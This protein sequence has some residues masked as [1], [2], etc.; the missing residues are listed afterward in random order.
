MDCIKCDSRVQKFGKVKQRQRYQCLNCGT[1]FTEISLL[2]IKERE[3]KYIKIKDM[4]ILSGMSTTE[5]GKALSTS[6]TVPQRILKKMGI[7]RTISEAKKGKLRGTSLP[8]GVIIERYCNGESSYAIAKD[9]GYAKSSILNILEDNGIPRDNEY[10]YEH[11]N[12]IEMLGMYLDGCSMLVISKTLNIPYTT[13]NTR[14][15]KFSVVR[16]ED[17]HGLGINYDDYVKILPEFRKYWNSVI[18]ETN[19][20]SIHTLDNSDKRGL[21]GVDGAYHLDHKFSIF[22]GFKQGVEP[23]IIGNINNLEFIPWE[24]NLS[25]GSNCSITL[26]ELKPINL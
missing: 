10:N 15:H 11:E 17:K 6:S 2:K 22:E 25:K 14:L 1:T 4:Y 5:I 24:D 20:Q 26:E 3:A 18:N 12:D 13:I 16:T 9:L 8:V 21:T 19:K 23:E 7:T